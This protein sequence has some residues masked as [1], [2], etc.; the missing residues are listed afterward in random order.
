MFEFVGAE[1]PSAH[2]FFNLLKLALGEGLPEV[3]GGNSVNKAGA[4]L[5]GGDGICLIISSRSS[6][7]PCR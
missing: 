3:V 4:G 2:T 7:G 6:V 1:G 5:P